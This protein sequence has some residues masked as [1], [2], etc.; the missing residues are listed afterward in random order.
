MDVEISTGAVEQG[1]WETDSTG[2]QVK[3]VKT[4]VV[5]AEWEDVEG[6]GEREVNDREEEE[7]EEEE[8]EVD[9]IEVVGSGKRG[10]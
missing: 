5:S 2:S 10:S 3:I 8:E 9:V 6:E 7:E 1:R 4:T